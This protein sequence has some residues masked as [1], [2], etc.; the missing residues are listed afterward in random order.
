MEDGFSQLDETSEDRESSPLNGASFAFPQL[1][2]TS[3]DGTVRLPEAA[4]FIFE[5]YFLVFK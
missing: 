3:S 5:P 4:Y 1:L 2:D